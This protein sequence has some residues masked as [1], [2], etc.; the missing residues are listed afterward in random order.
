MFK[1]GE[2]VIL[3]GD[4]KTVVTKVDRKGNVCVAA[5]RS[6]RFDAKGH[7]IGRIGTRQINHKIEKI[8]Q[9][10]RNEEVENKKTKLAS[11]IVSI[12]IADEGVQHTETYMNSAITFHVGAIDALKTEKDVDKYL[13]TYV[14]KSNIRKDVLDFVNINNAA[15]KVEREEVATNG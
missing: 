8:M 10:K 6:I 4:T 5:L 9:K 11:R 13:S 3:D 12:M 15:K 14:P 1:L 7:Q 2:K